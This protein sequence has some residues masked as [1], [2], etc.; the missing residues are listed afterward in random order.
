MS[1]SIPVPCRIPADYCS[2]AR[3]ESRDRVGRDDRMGG[4]NATRM[5]TCME[6][7]NDLIRHFDLITKDRGFGKTIHTDSA[8]EE[9][10]RAKVRIE[11][12]HRLNL[13]SR[14]CVGEALVEEVS[15][16]ESNS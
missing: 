12:S 2:P 9:M 7:C 16:D 14:N 5:N 4:M 1:A 8:C 3:T 13:Q 10:Y 15:L 11:L 6:Y